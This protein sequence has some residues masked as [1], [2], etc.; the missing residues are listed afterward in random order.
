MDDELEIARSEILSSMLDFLHRNDLADYDDFSIALVNKLLQAK[1]IPS[2]SV[3]QVLRLMEGLNTLFF[4]VNGISRKWFAQLFCLEMGPTVTPKLG[5]LRRLNDIA[6]Q[7]IFPEMEAVT[8]EAATRKECEI[9]CEERKIQTAIRKVL[10]HKHAQPI[11][12]R[13]ADTP[14]EVADIEIFRMRVSNRWLRFAIV[15]KGYRSSPGK[16]LKWKD[17]AHQVARAYQRGSPDYVLLFA[18]KDPADGLVTSLEEYSSSVGRR[19]L[20]IFVPPIDLVRLL[21][22]NKLL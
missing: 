22:A 6:L 15:V 12:R 2:M 20:V 3:P 10:R 4:R 1:D 8:E 18:G 13:N 21:I 14:L 11:P 16:T 17:V 7:D 9:Q 5:G 19:G